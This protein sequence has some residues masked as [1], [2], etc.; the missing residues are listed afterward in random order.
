MSDVVDQGNELAQQLLDNY[1]EVR[2]PAPVLTPKGSCHNPLCDLDLDDPRALY[3][4]A[5]CAKEHEKLE[6][7]Q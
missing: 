5:E 6:G 1:L 7:R 2:R 4:G 3:C